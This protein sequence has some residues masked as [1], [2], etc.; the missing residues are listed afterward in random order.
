MPSCL[1]W[2]RR[3]QLRETSGTKCLIEIQTKEWAQQRVHKLKFCLNRITVVLL[4]SAGQGIRQTQPDCKDV[5][6]TESG[7]LHLGT[8]YWRPVDRISAFHHKRDH[9]QQTKQL[10][11][12]HLWEQRTNREREGEQSLSTAIDLGSP[13][14]RPKLP[15]LG[16]CSICHLK[17]ETKSGVVSQRRR[18]SHSRLDYHVRLT[19]ERG[20]VRWWWQHATSLDRP[21]FLHRNKRK[22]DTR[23][24]I[25]H[26][27]CCVFTRDH[28]GP[29]YFTVFNPNS[30]IKQYFCYHVWYV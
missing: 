19:G 10:C 6:A 28:K 9:R 30:V 5:A 18:E 16:P 24:C 8:P 25:F 23:N 17:P 3:T 15:S 1:V 20:S 21:V 13:Q 4:L 22:L 7:P 26:T 14:R 2:V 27:L 12:S 29:L 11:Q